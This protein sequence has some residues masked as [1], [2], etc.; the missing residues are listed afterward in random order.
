M[1][2]RKGGRI[3]GVLVL[4]ILCAFLF[5]LVSLLIVRPG[6]E[7]TPAP[8]K[9]LADFPE[10]VS[11]LSTGNAQ[12]LSRAFS[13]PLPVLP[14]QTMNGEIRSVSFEENSALM[15]TLRYSA[16]TLTCVQPALAA[17]LL[18]SSTLT[19]ASVRIDDRDGFSILSMPAI[20]LKNEQAHCFYFSDD[21]AAYTLYSD[22][23]DLSTLVYFAS[24][25]KWV[26]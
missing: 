5:S 10:P 21:S 14:S 4:F 12:A 6:A 11:Y 1:T 8:S 17:P 13:H 3:F 15:V 18:F 20:Y 22:Q 19:P 2:I 9:V 24:N 16:F 26:N 7:T 25:L 23:T